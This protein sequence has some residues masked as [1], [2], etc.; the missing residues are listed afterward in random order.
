MQFR[1]AAGWV[2]GLL[3]AINSNAETL[4]RLVVITPD[5]DGPAAIHCASDIDGWSESGKAVPR[6]A[7]GIYAIDWMLKPGDAIEYK[8]NREGAWAS[9]E[10]LADGGEVPN[11]RLT[12]AASGPQTIVNIVQR[13]ADRPAPAG[14]VAFNAPGDAAASDGKAAPRKSTRTGDIRIH[15]DFESPQLGNKRTVQVWL[16]PGYGSD[17]ARRYPV[18]YM[19]DGN[20][21]FDAATAFGG[22]EWAADETATR[23]IAESRIRPLIIVAI[24]N[25]PDRANEY[26]PTADAKWG[27]GKGDKFLAFIAETLKPFIDKTYRT[28]PDRANTSIGGSS[29]GGLISLYA[30]FKRPDVFGSAAVVSPSVWWNDRQIIAFVRDAAA[31]I[32]PRLWIDIGTDEGAKEGRLE[33]Y[34]R[35]VSDCRD[36]VA[37]LEKRGMQGDGDFKFEII[38]GGRHNERDWAAR[39]DRILLFLFP[40]D[41]ATTQPTSAASQ[42]SGR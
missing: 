11:R 7:P 1:I 5:A 21:V 10:K 34:N 23:L 9:V 33:N 30:A 20:N 26:T 37:A 16:P 40:A 15:A 18:L 36:L 42:A 38:E 8:F 25:T 41:T 4:V 13:W 19:H 6:V 32:K 14:S 3:L 2:I 31:E 29:L 17:A 35:A 27:G 22:V 39:F 12:V 28:L 24:D